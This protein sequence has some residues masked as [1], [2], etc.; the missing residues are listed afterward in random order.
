MNWKLAGVFALTL[1]VAAAEEEV[2]FRSDVSLVRVDVQVLDRNSDALTRLEREDFVLREQGREVEIRNFAAENMPVDILLLL[3]VS[4]SMRPHLEQVARASRGALSV[5]GREDRV[6]VMVFDR[7]TRLRAPFRGNPQ[8]ASRE[9]DSLLDQESF[10]GGTDITRALVDAARYVER[11]ARTEARRA[12]VIVTDDQTEFERDETRVGR[13]L[14]SADAVL[15]V[16]VA[17]AIVPGYGRGGGG[18]GQFPPR[19]QPSGGGWPGSGGTWPG[20]GGTGGGW[21]GGGRGWPGGGGGGPVIIGPGGGGGRGPAMGRTRP[22][23]TEEIARDSGGDSLILSDGSAVERTLRRIRSRYALYFLLPDEA[24][25][26][27]RGWWM[28]S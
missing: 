21:P 3:D 22:A 6:G 15:S 25:R 18:G 4:G 26:G 17:Q 13:A 7:A 23:G 27:S 24:R 12:I 10:N 11:N 8:E 19:R 16:L 20:G 1:G 9:L 28:R 5:L 14:T 2:I